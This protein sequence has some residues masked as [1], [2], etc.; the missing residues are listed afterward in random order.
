MPLIVL[1]NKNILHILYF[2]TAPIKAQSEVSS[3][4]LCYFPESNAKA[5]S[6]G[7]AL[8]KVPLRPAGGGFPSCGRWAALHRLIATILWLSPNSA[9]LQSL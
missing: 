6:T 7:Y 9:T 8:S 4:R 3:L 2:F 1:S 5:L